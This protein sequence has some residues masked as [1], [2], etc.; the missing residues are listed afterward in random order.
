MNITHF[1][2]NSINICGSK[3]A[4]FASIPHYTMTTKNVLRYTSISPHEVS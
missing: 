2:I 3:F 1:N 4:Y